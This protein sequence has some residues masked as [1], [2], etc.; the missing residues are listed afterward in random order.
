MILVLMVIILVAGCS[1]DVQ[2][3]ELKSVDDILDNIVKEVNHIEDNKVS[4]D[5]GNTLDGSDE[6]FT[7]TRN[8]RS[9]SCRRTNSTEMR[10]KK[11][12]GTTFGRI[13]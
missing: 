9:G 10:W 12:I 11:N 6:K 5:T 4:T 8:G 2:G 3:N 1:F 7:M 13:T